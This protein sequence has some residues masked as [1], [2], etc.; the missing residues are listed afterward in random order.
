MITCSSIGDLEVLHAMGGDEVG[1]L[2]RIEV[3]LTPEVA[4]ALEARDAQLFE[5]AA[6]I[7]SEVL[8]T[9]VEDTY[10]IAAVGE[11]TTPDLDGSVPHVS[12]GLNAEDILIDEVDFAVAEELDREIIHLRDVAADEHIGGKERPEADVGILLVG[13]ET[14]VAQVAA[15]SHLA[16]DEH[17]G[18][19]PVSGATVGLYLYLTLEADVVHRSPGVGDVARRTPGVGID[20]AAPLPYFRHT[21][22]AE[23][24]EDVARLVAQALLHEQVGTDIGSDGLAALLVECA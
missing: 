4:G 18:I 8:R 24:V 15:P 3:L 12:A 23:A 14:A 13:R 20:E 17:V 10:G 5:V 16:Y 21:I 9:G 22:L 6:E 1:G 11:R 7:D 2:A 19:I